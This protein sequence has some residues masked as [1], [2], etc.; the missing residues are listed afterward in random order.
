MA[1]VTET[2]TFNPTSF[3]A[4]SASNTIS[5]QNGFNTTANTSSY[6]SLKGGRQ[7]RY[8]TIYYFNLDEIPNNASIKTIDCKIRTRVTGTGSSYI[9]SAQTMTNNVALGNMLVLSGTAT[10]GT[11]IS[12]PITGQTTIENV[13]N[14][15]IK[16]FHPYGGNNRYV[17]FY[18][19]NLAITYEYDDGSSTG[20]G[21][22]TK[23]N[24]V[25]S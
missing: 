9:G 4:S 10:D 24:G 12:L 15:N 2:K 7:T 25:W 8:N 23:E 14:F 20:S 22:S 5:G 21:V 11:V 16:I 18:G 3:S 17:Y 19:A 13:K 1:I 6:S